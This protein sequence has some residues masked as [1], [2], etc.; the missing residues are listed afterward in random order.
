MSGKRSP[1]IDQSERVLP[2]LRRCPRAPPTQKRQESR[3]FRSPPLQRCHRLSKPALALTAQAPICTRRPES[4]LQPRVT[5]PVFLIEDYLGVEARPLDWRRS[6]NCPRHRDR[7][8][9][10]V[11]RCRP[12]A[13][14]SQCEPSEA[15]QPENTGYCFASSSAI[16]TSCLHGATSWPP[17]PVRSRRAGRKSRISPKARCSQP[18][19]RA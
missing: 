8:R 6:W 4:A 11:R 18:R 13:W 2:R 14:S 16:P 10:H 5:R 7:G 15:P 19:F 17:V 12:G 3:T 1:Q 9:L